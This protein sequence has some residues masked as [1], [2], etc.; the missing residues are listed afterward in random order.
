[1][2]REIDELL[3]RMLAKD[4]AARPE[5]G[6]A[7]LREI[8][9]ALEQVT[10]SARDVALR[11]VD[12][13]P[14]AALSE[15]EA[16]I[17]SVVLAS[18]GVAPQAAIDSVRNFATS[19]GASIEMLPDGSLFAL[20]ARR[21]QA[22]EQAA[23][24][25]KLALLMRWAMPNR[26]Y[27]LATGRTALG[28]RYLVG[29]AIDRASSLLAAPPRNGVRVDEVTAGLLGSRFVVEQLL[30]TAE[31]EVTDDPRVVLGKAVPCVG[32]ER[33]LATLEGLYDESVARARRAS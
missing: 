26:V 6:A 25:A 7:A 13:G 19:V 12:S 29:E 33:E 14:P 24:A 30:L 9:T 8:E 28:A 11:R 27:V 18:P 21:G 23:A 31:R 17:A 15:S 4:P 2:P 5:N 20:L 10:P 1:M 3:A 16:Y 22:R 32:R